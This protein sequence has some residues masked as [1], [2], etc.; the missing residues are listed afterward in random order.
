MRPYSWL[1]RAAVLSTY[2]VHAASSVEEY[3]PR[4]L[5]DTIEALGL[6]KYL[7][8]L[9]DL[10]SA[11]RSVAQRCEVA[12]NVLDLIL[13]SEIQLPGSTAY[14]NNKNSYWVQQQSSLS[15]ACFLAMKSA[16]SVAIAVT[17][18]RVTRCPFIVRGGGHSDVPSASNTEDGITIDLSPMKSVSLAADQ[19][20]VSVGGGARWLDVYSAL[21]PKN[22]TVIGGRTASVGVGGMSFFSSMEGFACDNVVNY[23]V[24]MADGRLLNVNRDSYPDLYFALRGGGNNF[25]VVIRFDLAVFKQGPM[26]GGVR[27]HLFSLDIKTILID[28]ITSFNQH[29]ADDPKLAVI[30]SFSYNYGM[31]FTSLVADYA[32]P[33]ADPDILASHFGDL[34][35]IT[36][37]SDTT[38][39]TSLSDLTEELGA[40]APIGFRNQFTTA[41]FKNG[42]K[43]LNGIVDI[44]ITEV[45]R[46]K[47]SISTTSGFV[48]TVAFQPMPT[49]MTSKFS[50][51]GGNALG[52]SP[53]EGPLI[54]AQFNWQWASSADD[55][56]V[57]PAIKSIVDQ[58][59]ALAEEMGL[60]NDFV[61]LN[62]AAPHQK[63]IQGYGAENVNKLRGA[64][65]KYDPTKVFEI[66]QPGGFK[67]DM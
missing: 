29:V 7:G 22:L 31:L 5:N 47:D 44:F 61:Y 64:Q 41:T 27:A 24:V 54:L 26:W 55:H 13:P 66:L 32:L 50:K 20:V 25:G 46:V 56:I 10:E 2:G 37:A 34:S 63:P 3:T 62:Y 9:P 15:P 39:V 59:N 57:I 60:A 49:V 6:E 40:A 1:V 8:G 17:V 18:S 19:K 23:A 28:G 51:R 58:S 42:A 45:N 48:P 30:I 35:S 53:S 14:T 67:L 33:Q 12:C 38:R 43:L 16:S 21:D 52:V 4:S 11:K 36:P 65:K